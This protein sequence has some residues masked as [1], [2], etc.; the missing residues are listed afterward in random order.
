VVKP[1][2]LKSALYSFCLQFTDQKLVSLQAALDDAQS[3]ANAET[4]S[5]AGDKHDTGRAMMQLEVERL[6]KQRAEASQMKSDLLKINPALTNTTVS[7]GALVHTSKGNYFIAIAAGKIELDG[8]LYFAVSTSSPVYMQL[9]GLKK[10][11]TVS[12]TNN[13]VEITGI[14]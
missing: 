7:P 1:A 8:T 10:G 4:K 14:V 5:T 6:S 3:G 11:Q 2:D 13:T 9:K 12:L